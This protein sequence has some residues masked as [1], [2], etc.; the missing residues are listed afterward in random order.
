MRKSELIVFGL[1]IISFLIGIISYTYLPAQVA[2][3]W[4]TQGQVDGYMSKFWGIFLLP[5][6]LVGIMLLFIAIPRIDPLKKNIESF[7]LY[8]D[9]FIILFTLFMLSVE[10]QIIFW[11]LGTKLS[12]NIL[13][14]IW[15]GIMFYYLGILCKH[16]KR[17]WFIGI[18]TP[19]TLSSDAVWDKTHQLGGTLFKIAGVITFIGVFFQNYVFYFVIVPA[20]LVAIY[21]II[22]S[23][24]EYKKETK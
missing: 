21:T 7:R 10:L 2:S 12:P 18:R 11:N 8:Y 16:S 9:G 22:Y 20:M 23:Y 4:N 15:L 17:N 19:W 14:P 13:I 5:I 24:L 3:H 6:I 1:V